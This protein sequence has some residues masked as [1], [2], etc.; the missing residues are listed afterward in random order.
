MSTFSKRTFDA[1]LLARCT[2]AAVLN[3][4]VLTMALLRPA[5]SPR[6]REEVMLAVTSVNDCRYCSWAHTGLA[7]QQGIDLDALRQLL[8]REHIADADRPEVVAILFAQHFAATGRRPD[9]AARAALERS[10]PQPQRR[11]IMAY[12]HAIYF[13]NLSG[14]SADAWLARLRG[15]PVADGHPLAEAFAAVLAA[16]IL[17]GIRLASRRVRPE[18]M[19]RET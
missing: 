17:A 12:I 6:L 13:A 8:D 16:P 3:L 5:T 4:P 14:N 1:A 9:A 10:F 18:L 19:Q 2:G 7:L 15:E 11:E